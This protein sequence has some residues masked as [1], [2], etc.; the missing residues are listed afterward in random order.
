VAAPAT[1]AAAAGT[2]GAADAVVA[3]SVV[4]DAGMTL[5]IGSV[6]AATGRVVEVALIATRVV[7][8]PACG[9]DA[10]RGGGDCGGAAGR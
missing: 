1:S 6:A 4:G 5:A 3:G 10:T 2:I 9:A 7:A 8:G